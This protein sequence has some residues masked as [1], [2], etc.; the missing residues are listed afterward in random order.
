M[1]SVANDFRSTFVDSI[2]VFDCRLSGVNCVLIRT[3][4]YAAITAMSGSRAG[5]GGGAW[6]Q[7]PPGKLQNFRVS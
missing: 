7:E 5:E 6:G 4:S 2:N 1:D 3:A